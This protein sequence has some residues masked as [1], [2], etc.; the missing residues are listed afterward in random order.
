VY[1]L[2]VIAFHMLV[3]EPPFVGGTP[4]EILLQHLNR[5]VPALAPR[6][7]EVA[8]GL[9]ELV[10]R[11]LAKSH[12]L[13]PAATAIDQELARLRTATASPEYAS[14]DVGDLADVVQ[15]IPSTEQV[16]T[17]IRVRG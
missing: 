12:D 3:G 2:G 11:M 17:R 7:P 4:V 15:A 14:Y 8:Y 13:R 1:G 9:I 5:P 6:C 16:T 10:E